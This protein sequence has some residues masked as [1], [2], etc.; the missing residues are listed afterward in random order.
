MEGAIRDGD[1]SLPAS[2]AGAAQASS[3][4]GTQLDLAGSVQSSSPS[5]GGAI[6]DGDVS[7]PASSAGADQI[8]DVPPNASRQA[9]YFAATLIFPDL[10]RSYGSDYP[11]LTFI[12][13]DD[14]KEISYSISH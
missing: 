11:I 8:Q 5:L 14:T 3:V 2:P 4:P 9:K 6:R 10:Y 12:L 7:L 1:V 13:L